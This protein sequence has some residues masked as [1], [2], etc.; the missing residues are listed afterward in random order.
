M[1]STNPQIQNTS[2]VKKR[3]TWILREIDASL[4]TLQPC[5]CGFVI[6]SRLLNFLDDY[7]ALQGTKVLEDREVRASFRRV[8]E[9]SPERQLYTSIVKYSGTRTAPE[10]M[11]IEPG[12]MF[13]FN[14]ITMSTQVK[15]TSS[16]HCAKYGQI[17]PPPPAKS[18]TKH[19][20]AQWRATL[21]ATI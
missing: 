1:P 20:T 17:S 15:Q 8:A 13:V 9:D 19:P 2:S 5:Y 6:R 3:H 18:S 21:N 14:Y 7:I 12:I 10:W 11:D 4:V 16:R